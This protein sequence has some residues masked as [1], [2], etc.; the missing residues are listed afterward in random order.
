MAAARLFAMKRVARDEL[1]K[2]K[3]ICDASGAFQFRVESVRCSNN[4]DILPEFVAQLPDAFNG[5]AQPLPVPAH[6]HLVP[7][8]AAK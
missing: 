3:K 6:P 2:L 1:A 5:F 7:H 4:P 8:D